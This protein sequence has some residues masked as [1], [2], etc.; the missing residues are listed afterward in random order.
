M[1]LIYLGIAAVVIVL[2]QL[3]KIFI[4]TNYSVGEVHQI[5]PHVLSFNYLQNNGGAGNILSGK[6]WLF[7]LISAI[8]I[9]ILLYFLIKKGKTKKEIF[10]KIGLA[11]L[12]G[13]IVGNLI[14][15]I[16]L[17]YVIDMLQLDFIQFNIFNIADSAI[18]VGIAMLF[19]YLIFLDREEKWTN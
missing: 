17:G 11:V 18:T 9:P 2:D 14:D 13:G 1:I 12:L 8:V 15:R 5:I 6:M 3:L 7:Y 10:F 16:R 4:A 19:I